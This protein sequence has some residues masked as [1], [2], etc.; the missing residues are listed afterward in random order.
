MVSL[1]AFVMK[2]YKAVHTNAGWGGKLP[3]VVRNFGERANIDRWLHTLYGN[4]FEPD[5]IEK[6]LPGF[7]E[8]EMQFPIL[9]AV[10]KNWPH[11]VIEWQERGQRTVFV[12]YE[13][14]L[15]NAE[16]CFTEVMSTYQSDKEVDVTLVKDAIAYYSFARQAGRERGEE[17]RQSFMRKGIKGDWKNYFSTEARQVFDHYAGDLLVELGYEPDKSWTK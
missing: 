8:K 1:Y 3:W 7:I 9:P 10:R 17:N 5:D 2:G 6:N 11:H 15:V 4:N 14:M 13:Q 12:R 16:G